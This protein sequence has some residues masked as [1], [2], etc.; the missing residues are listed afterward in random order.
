[1]G[2]ALPGP[3]QYRMV[4]SVSQ[5]EPHGVEAV[6]VVHGVVGRAAR[7]VLVGDADAVAAVVPEI[8]RLDRA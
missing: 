6:V 7:L 4:K 3:V 2:F 5:L 8:G 1:M